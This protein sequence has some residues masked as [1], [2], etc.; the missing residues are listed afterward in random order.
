MLPLA[1]APAIRRGRKV[2]AAAKR[3][4]KPR[5]SPDGAP[6]SGRKPKVPAP[7]IKHGLG[8]RPEAKS[9]FVSQ[10]HVLAILEDA[11]EPLTTFKI[12]QALEAKLNIT[13]SDNA[14]DALLRMAKTHGKI[15]C[16]QQGEWAIS[17]EG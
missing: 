7:K 8:K 9:Y 13:P 1:D 14:L 12:K 2:K 5:V 15:C 11:G 6:V 3:G 4:R 10:K 16:P 17:N